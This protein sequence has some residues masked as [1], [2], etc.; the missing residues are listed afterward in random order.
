MVTEQH[1]QLAVY[2]EVGAKR[3][4]AGALSWPGWCRVARDEAGAL[5]ALVEYAPRYE[6]LLGA[7][8]IAFAAPTSPA[9][10]VVVERLAGGSGTDFGVPELSPADDMRAM[11]EEELRGAEHLLR[12]C[13]QAFDAAAE[14]AKGKMLR[15]GPRGGG[16]DL[17]GMVDHV[18]SAERSYVARLGW[19]W[20]QPPPEEPAERA[21]QVREAALLALGAAARD[22]LPKRGPRG[23]VIWTPRYFVRRAAWHVLDHAWELEDRIM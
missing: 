4:I 8:G 22:E 7:A 16:R 11:N 21:Q 14:A 1:E 19:R 5:Q 13:W 2:L 20:G 17:D 15:V 23:G 6:R 3:T 10:L 9:S 12:A 18:V